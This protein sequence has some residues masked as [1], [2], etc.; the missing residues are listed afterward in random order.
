[1]GKTIGGAFALALAW[2]PLAQ[3]QDLFFSVWNDS[4]ETLWEFYVSPT[5]SS[6]WGPDLLGADVVY[7]G[8]G[9]DVVIADG[10]STCSYDILGV[11]A[12]GYEW[13]DFAI[14]LCDLG[15]YVFTD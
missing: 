15:E 12:D 2:V 5:T 1:M 7:P 3:A 9:G 11:F 13:A 14:D 10:L 6:D 4:S 8:E